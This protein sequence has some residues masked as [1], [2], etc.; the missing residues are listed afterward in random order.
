MS[1]VPLHLIL[2]GY[3]IGGVSRGVLVGFDCDHHEFILYSS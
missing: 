2:W 1:P 3:V